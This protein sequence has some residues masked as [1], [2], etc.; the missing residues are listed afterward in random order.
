MPALLFRRGL[1]AATAT[2]ATAAEAT[3]SATD[4]HAGDVQPFNFSPSQ[5]FD[6]CDGDLDG[7]ISDGWA[8]N[9]VHT[10]TVNLLSAGRAERAQRREVDR[11]RLCSGHV[12]RPAVALSGR[13][14]A[15][16]APPHAATGHAVRH[17]S[18]LFL[19]VICVLAYCNMR[20][21]Y[22]RNVPDEVVE[23]LERL[24]AQDATSVSAVAV[25]E[26]AEVS[27]RADNPAL[28]GALPDHAVDTAAILEDLDAERAGR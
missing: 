12:P 18:T 19:Q 2:S 17:A 4:M 23:R 1:F 3:P 27:R 15:A 8:Y 28:L 13:R 9:L 10:C 25:R 24:A 21:L 14:G 5:R 16:P 11:S 20:T 7:Y 26:L 6:K 22:L